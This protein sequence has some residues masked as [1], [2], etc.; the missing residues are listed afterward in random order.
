MYQRAIT[1]I[2]GLMI[3]FKASDSVTIN[4]KLD[5]GTGP[6]HEILSFTFFTS[7]RCDIMNGIERS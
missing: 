3:G 6:H 4:S 7:E 5:K 2:L 1:K